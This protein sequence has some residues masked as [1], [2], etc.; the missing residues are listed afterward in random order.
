[1]SKPWK[2]RERKLR[3]H[4][5]LS[6]MAGSREILRLENRELSEVTPTM[7]MLTRVP[8]LAHLL[9]QMPAVNARRP[10]EDDKPDGYLESDK[11]FIRNNEEAAVWLLEHAEEIRA[12]LQVRKGPCR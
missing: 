3:H 9:K 7:R 5:H 10:F 6:L 12:A 11:D 8:V 1:V 2:W 4:S